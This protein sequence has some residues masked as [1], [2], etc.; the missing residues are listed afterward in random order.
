MP[1]TGTVIAG[2]IYRD[3]VLIGS[4]SQASDPQPGA[5]GATNL[6]TG[7]RWTVS[8]LRRVGSHPL[9]AG[10]SGQTGTSDRLFA[11]LG[12]ATIHGNQLKR[13]PGVQAV[14]DRVYRPEYEAAA[15]R[16]M[17]PPGMMPIFISGLAAVW[18][19]DGPGLLEHEMNADSS[20]HDH[21]HAIGSGKPTAYAAYRALGGQELCRLSE[22]TAILAL[23]RIMQTTVAVEMAFVAEPLHIWR[24]NAFGA[25]QYGEVELDY[26]RAALAA[27][28]ARD[29]EAL[30]QSDAAEGDPD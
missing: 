8:K 14:L 20:W 5:A 23:L 4:D 7:V 24:V 30:F 21:F 1:V 17:P 18:T 28:I 25:A 2:L 26:H 9:V 13:R 19:E 15:A 29:R 10:F 11:T 6:M 16:S 27:W 12:A 3:G 22:R